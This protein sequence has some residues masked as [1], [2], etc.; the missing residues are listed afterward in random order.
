MVL[1][2]GKALRLGGINKS[3]IDIG[4]VTIVDRTVKILMPL[5]REIIMAGW[6]SGETLPAGTTAVADNFKSCGPL[7]GI[8]A[9]MKYSS[10]PYLFVFAGDMPLLS[11]ELIIRQAESFLKETSDLCVARIGD[12]VEPLH[13]IYNCRTHAA[14]EKYMSTGN[15]HAVR[16]FFGLLQVT[17][18]D[19]PR[20]EEIK[21]AFTN[22]NAPED[23]V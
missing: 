20:T 12:M 15:R 4:G 17:Y 23:L 11:G 14:L 9:A 18:F 2:G 21:R 6:P 5:F 16:D 1:T 10:A 8:E 22:I 3:L 19:F 13:S 7:A